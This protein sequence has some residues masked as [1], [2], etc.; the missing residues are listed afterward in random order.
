MHLVGLVSAVNPEWS[1]L[2]VPDNVFDDEFGTIPKNGGRDSLLDMQ[3]SLPALGTSARPGC[4][5]G[6]CKGHTDIIKEIAKKM[7]LSIYSL[8]GA[9]EA[10]S[11]MFNRAGL[12]PMKETYFRFLLERSRLRQDDGNPARISSFNEFLQ[13]ERET[14]QAAAAG[15]SYLENYE[16]SN[17]LSRPALNSVM[18]LGLADFHA[19]VSERVKQAELSELRLTELE[20]KMI[21]A[22]CAQTEKYE[23]EQVD[24]DGED[25]RMSEGPVNEEEPSLDSFC[26]TEHSDDF[27]DNSADSDAG[28][29][30]NPGEIDITAERVSEIIKRALGRKDSAGVQ[31]DFRWKYS[32]AHE[33]LVEDVIHSLEDLPLKRRFER[34]GPLEDALNLPRMS[35]GSFMTRARISRKRRGVQLRAF[36]LPKVGEEADLILR[37]LYEQNPK[38]LIPNLYEKLQTFNLDP[39]PS[40]NEVKHWVRYRRY[41][42]AANRRIALIGNQGDNQVIELKKKREKSSNHLDPLE[43]AGA[44]EYSDPKKKMPRD[45]TLSEL[46]EDAFV[47]SGSVTH[48]RK[49]LRSSAES[50]IP[51]FLDHTNFPFSSDSADLDTLLIE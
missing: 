15:P 29:S 47:P 42:L 13:E 25:Q 38:I 43:Q 5:T 20:N 17:N 30:P 28:H 26:R 19:K 12:A 36:R 22:S 40:F 3:Q 45:A 32:I 9:Y 33:A 21:T 2:E 44:S 16:D 31:S 51:D 34:L 41:S 50:T 8:S 18:G 11:R 35:Q 10:A 6:H 37:E 49:S 48:Q 24:H 23:Q 1:S 7:Q 39:C 46:S 4:S 27:R 14:G